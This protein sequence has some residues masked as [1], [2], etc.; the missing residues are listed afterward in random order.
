MLN[1]YIIATLQVN[2]TRY[3]KILPAF[4]SIAQTNNLKLNNSK[5]FKLIKRIFIKSILYN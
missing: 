3:S 1:P 4:K 5:D 2:K